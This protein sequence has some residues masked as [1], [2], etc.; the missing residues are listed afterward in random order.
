MGRRKPLPEAVLADRTNTKT[1]AE[2]ATPEEHPLHGKDGATAPNKVPVTFSRKGKVCLLCSV[3]AACCST[4]L[5]QMS[6]HH[7]RSKAP[8]DYCCSIMTIRTLQAAKQPARGGA[9]NAACTPRLDSRRGSVAESAS[10][11]L[12]DFLTPLASEPQSSPPEA[13]L[14]ARAE[15]QPTASKGKTSRLGGPVHADGCILNMHFS[16]VEGQLAPQQ[17]G[18]PL[19]L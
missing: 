2:R 17:G 6:A 4:I 1:S 7:T 15:G 14:T 13:F 18:L 5:S 19:Q 9:E 16:H 12:T 11:S 10:P 3:L 8:D